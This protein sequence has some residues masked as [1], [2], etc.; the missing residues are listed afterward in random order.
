MTSRL[1]SKEK[2][3]AKQDIYLLCYK[4]I[5]HRCYENTEKYILESANLTARFT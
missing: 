1:K 5:I 4:T 3:K 2:S